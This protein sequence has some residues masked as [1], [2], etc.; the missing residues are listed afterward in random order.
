MSLTIGKLAQ[1]TG[2]TV[3]ALHHYHSVGL[4][5]PSQRTVS[6]YRL[7]SDEDVARLH[8]VQAL[9][10]L[11]FSLD[12]I[13]QI[14]SNRGASLP[15]LVATQ[16][17]HLDE[18]IRQATAL[19][20]RLVQLQSTVAA[21]EDTCIDDWLEAVELITL[22]NRSFTK[23]ELQVLLERSCKFKRSWRSLLVE[24]ESAMADGVDPRSGHARNLAER[25]LKLL[26]QR[27]AGDVG[28]AIKAK[29][30][31]RERR[32]LARNGF[33]AELDNYMSHVG[34][35]AH[36][37]TWARHLD[38]KSVAR[39]DLCEETMYE[40]WRRVT[41]LRGARSSRT[42][43]APE[44]QRLF[45]Q[46][47]SLLD[48]CAGSDRTLKSQMLRA[49]SVDRDLQLRWALDK[50]LVRRLQSIRPTKRYLK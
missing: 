31:F 18:R 48:H 38:P 1:L 28:L 47:H 24:L 26:M 4:L 45:G 14:L 19:R 43:D 12:E 3:R 32:L 23:E 41:E 33:N 39:L 17:A 10:S 29:L 9:R 5:V 46:C 15:Q 36:R 22:Y 21:A 50:P 30:A 25:S 27:S 6:G 34:I 35:C 20:S 2:T 8:N 40:W 16:L 49:L 42:Q 7:Y 11:D 37:T 44:L 13:A